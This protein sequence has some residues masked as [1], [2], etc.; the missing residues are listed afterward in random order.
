[1]RKKLLI[2]GHECMTLF[3][4]LIFSGKP[5]NEILIHLERQIWLVV[6][7]FKKSLMTSVL[8]FTSKSSTDGQPQHDGRNQTNRPTGVQRI[9]SSEFINLQEYTQ[10]LLRPAL[11]CNCSLKD[12]PPHPF[13]TPTPKKD[14]HLLQYMTKQ[15]FI[16][17]RHCWWKS[18]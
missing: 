11:I 13:P 14:T 10:S 18:N 12:P 4:I 2:I 6:F 15:N 17:I 16:S 8:N 7:Y 3:F 5:T 9:G 1:M